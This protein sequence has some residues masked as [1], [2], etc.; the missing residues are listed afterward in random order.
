MIASDYAGTWLLVAVTALLLAGGLVHRPALQA[1][2]GA[3]RAAAAA[4]HAE[5]PRAPTST[6][7]RLEPDYFRA[8]AATAE[9]QRARCVFVSTAQSPPGVT[10]DTE[11]IPNSEYRAA[12]LE[13]EQERVLEPL[14]DAAEE[15]ARRRRRRGSGGRRRA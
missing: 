11:Q 7:A 9:P 1:A 4:A 15:L 2:E 6:C 3:E 10:R 13:G 5:L 8:C 14:A 12:P